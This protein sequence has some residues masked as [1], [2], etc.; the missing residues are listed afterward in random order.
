MRPALV[1]LELIDI[2]GT[3]HILAMLQDMTAMKEA[4]RQ[5]AELAVKN[6]SVQSLR[7]YLS[8]FSHD[9]RNPL[10]VMVTSLYLL[11]HKIGAEANAVA[12]GGVWQP[13]A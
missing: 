11:K 6:Q 7:T 9:L 13:S 3:P 1:S 5:A 2:K 4:E 8:H 12:P 10:A